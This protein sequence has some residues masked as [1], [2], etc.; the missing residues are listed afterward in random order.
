MHETI[1]EKFIEKVT[2]LARQI[3][4]GDP[5]DPATN[6]GPIATAPQLAKVLRYIDIAH[7]DGARCILGGRRAEGPGLGAGQFVEPTIF[8]DVTPAMRIAR[9]EVF[10]PVLA[11][12][13]FE[14]E[15]EALRIA[16]DVAY[17]LVAG[18]WTSSMPRALRLSKALEVGTVWV[19]T[20]RTYSAMVP[21]G[22]RKHSG[23]AGRTEWRPSTSISRPRACFIATGEKPPANPFVMR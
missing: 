3:K 23:L 2:A 10:G 13:S 12:I 15:E 8:S 22:G 4:M 1:R 5:R 17:G 21:F 20:Y 9:E 7:A 6:V 11:V 19:N 16:N 18:L 14:T